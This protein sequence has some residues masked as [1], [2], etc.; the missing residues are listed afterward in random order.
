MLIHSSL[1]EAVYDV[2]NH[3]RTQQMFVDGRDHQACLAILPRLTA[4][5][6][7]VLESRGITIISGSRTQ[8][9]GAEAVD[10]VH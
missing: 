2:M 4:V 1:E 8:E 7:R 3:G 6:I 5:D 9:G 10:R